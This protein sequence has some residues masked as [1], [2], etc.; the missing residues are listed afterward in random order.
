MLKI[1]NKKN[2]NV[3]EESIKQVSPVPVKE[4]VNEGFAYSDEV[5][6]LTGEVGREIQT[7]LKEEGMMT[8]GFNN[9][10]G[11]TEYT[12]QQIQQVE[13]HLNSLSQNSEN[14]R[15]LV[16]DVVES[17]DNSSLEIDNARKGMS[18]LKEHMGSVSEVF[19]QFFNLFTQMQ[20]QYANINK[21]ATIITNIASQTNLLS[22]NAAIEAARVGESGRGFAVVA[23]EIK[24]LS[25]DTQNSTK[26][27][28][29][30]LKKMT[31]IIELLSNKSSEGTKVVSNTTDLINS[32]ESLLDNI[33]T[34]ENKVHEHVEK[35]KDSQEQNLAGVQEITANLRNIIDK[36]IKENEYLGELILSVQKKADFY[37]Y[38]LNHLN[39]IRILQQEY[40]A[41]KS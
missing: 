5:F 39:Q 14:T 12:T 33:V 40:E 3:K 36:S 18:S 31:E 11:G 34:A 35:V 8:F 23:N 19:D 17:L 37:L 22:L 27:I 20:H 32:A 4:K 2:A 9:L 28:M 13:E 24:K 10:R 41:K 7:L 15:L 30:S 1:F 26:D 25:V 6:G 38:M 16:D 21:F 29:E